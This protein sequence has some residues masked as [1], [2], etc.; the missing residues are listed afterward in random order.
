LVS[1]SPLL[2]V[3]LQPSQDDAVVDVELDDPVTASFVAGPIAN[4]AV[5]SSD[6]EKPITK[7]LPIMRASQFQER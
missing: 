1:V 7:I 2:S 5:L 6:A 4:A 3:E